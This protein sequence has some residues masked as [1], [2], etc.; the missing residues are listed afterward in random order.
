MEQ[1]S[2]LV[3]E[4]PNGQQALS[5]CI[6]GDS[7]PASIVE[8]LQLP[9]C[10]RLFILSGGAGNISPETFLRLTDLF[11]TVGQTISRIGCTVIDGGTQSGVMQLMG[12]ALSQ[13]ARTAPLIGVVPV[14]AEVGPN[15]IQA[16][17]ILEPHH[18]NFVL[19]ASSDW[20]AEVETMYGLAAYLGAQIPSVAMLV[21]GG[22]ISLI[23][24]E[25]NVKQGREIIVI[26]G[27]GRL[28]DEIT[29]AI[30]F[31]E[32]ETRDR[33]KAVVSKGRLILFNLETPPQELAQILEQRLN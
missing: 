25:K 4:F 31:P 1:L 17:N 12:E 14:Y 15:G 20:G 26:V 13:T 16:E 23:E 27:S 30:L 33:I 3:K 32:R 11:E 5:V 29:Q 9:R 6:N 19:I 8:S 2:T 22:G 18:S 7:D 28:A 10:S 24:V 21:N